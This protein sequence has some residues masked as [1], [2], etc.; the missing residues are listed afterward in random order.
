MSP[1]PTPRNVIG[2]LGAFVACSVVAGLI[3]AGLAL[4]AVGAG[5][6]A[7]SSSVDYFN[8]LPGNLAQPPLSEKSVVLDKNG[9]TLASFYEENRVPVPL[10]KISPNL[11]NAVVAIEDSR[12]YQHGGFDTKGLVRAF[13]TNQVNNTISQG[14]STLTQQYVK[15]VLVETAYARGDDDAALAARARNNGRKL[16][17]IRYAVGLEKKLTKQQILERYLNIVFFGGTVY[18]VQA[19]AKYYYNTSAAKLNLQQ[20]AMLAG[21]IQL[22]SKWSP[23]NHPKAAAQRRNIVLRRML[24]LKMIDQATYERASTQSLKAKVT[25][26]KNGCANSGY[27]GYF[28][29]YVQ[30][31]IV[32]GDGFKALGRTAKLRRN[33]L[34]RGG[35]TIRTTLDPKIQ[36]TAWRSLTKAVSPTDKSRVRTAAVTVQPGTGKILAM[37]QNTYFD[38]SAGKKKY[39]S[40]NY[41]TDH[42]YGNSAGFQTGST[43]K[44][45]TLATWLKSGR[46]LNDTVDATVTSRSFGSFRSCGSPLTPTGNVYKYFNSG[47]GSKNGNMRV[48]D[49]TANSVNTAYIAME[50]KLDLCDI[51]RTAESLG[52]RLAA[53][54]DPCSPKPTI[55]IPTCFPSLT[56]GVLDLSPLTQAAAYATFA[57]DGMYCKPVAIAAISDRDGKPVAVPQPSCKRSLDTDVARGVNA[58]LSR[59]LTNGTASSVGPLPDGRPASGKTG[60]TNGSVATWFVGYTPQ[61]ATAVWVG[62][63][64]PA[65]GLKFGQPTTLTRRTIDGTYYRNVFGATIAAPIW[66]DIMTPALKGA[67]IERFGTAPS[68]LIGVYHAPKKDK[69]DDDKTDGKRGRGGAGPK[70]VLLPR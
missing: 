1:A 69:K 53:P 50:Q 52:V 40:V 34:L 38:P 17:E 25:P 15:N 13:V 49:A 56:L 57:A 7:A 3:A 10:S 66:K 55:K 43:F 26:T 35:L 70:L 9:K 27:N 58:G 2:L 12:F 59:V 21:M 6:M 61:L 47:D 14:A 48:W 24:D 22:P 19:A 23:V 42:A 36:N 29:D 30:R 33:A 54:A 68:S 4:P 32:D 18:G 16:K 44:P 20:S 62:R 39:Q 28:C 46:T 51:A 5:G 37:S 63:P 60:T 64:N 67:K 31:L 65:R 41:S 45:F 11:L 8:D